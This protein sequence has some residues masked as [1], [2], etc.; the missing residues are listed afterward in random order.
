MARTFPEPKEEAQER[1]PA[2]SVRMTGQLMRFL[3]VTE[4]W[5]TRAPEEA[6]R[7]EARTVEPERVPLTV[8]VFL[9]REVPFTVREPE[10]ARRVAA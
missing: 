3:K 10:V 2:L 7:L 5:M 8:T 9:K 4:D 6:R 1:R